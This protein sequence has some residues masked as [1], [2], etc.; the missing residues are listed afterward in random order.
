M[1]PKGKFHPG[2]R[3]RLRPNTTRALRDRSFDTPS[4]ESPA[5]VAW[6]QTGEVPF[7]APEGSQLVCD[8]LANCTELTAGS[9]ITLTEVPVRIYTQ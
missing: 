1:A 9:P 2:A 6:A 7:T 4:G 8:P 5:A 3:P